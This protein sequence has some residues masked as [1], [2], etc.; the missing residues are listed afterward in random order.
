MK[1]GM[2]NPAP[3]TFCKRTFEKE[4][5][6]HENFRFCTSHRSRCNWLC[7]NSIRGPYGPLR[8][9]TVYKLGGGRTCE[10]TETEGDRDMKITGL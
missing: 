5:E 8:P 4:R 2:R 1:C 3:N 6:R 7:K 10:Q 9:K